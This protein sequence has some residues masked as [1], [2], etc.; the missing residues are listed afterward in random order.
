MVA[1]LPDDA[2]Q[3]T[4]LSLSY[5]NESWQLKEGGVEDPSSPALAKCWYNHLSLGSCQILR[6][7]DQLRRRTETFEGKEVVR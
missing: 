7:G 3:Q 1:L 6:G 4:D 5:T 2:R